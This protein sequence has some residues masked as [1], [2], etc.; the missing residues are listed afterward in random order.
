MARNASTSSSK[1]PFWG[2]FITG[3]VVGLAL[4]VGVALL[5]SRNNPF[6]GSAP[7]SA[8][9][10]PEPVKKASPT[11]SPT[12]DFY[13]SLPANTDAGSGNA[14]PPAA[15]PQFWLQAG[16]FQHPEEADNM[17]AK[18]ALLGLEATIES[19]NIPDKGTLYRVRVGPLASA[20][21]QEATRKRLTENAIP[22]EPVKK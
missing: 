10:A 9:A 12:Y 22:A 4:A 15:A 16:A 5:V 2:G 6:M 1:S 8:P 19:A 17:K 14:T 13:K 18:L 21:E 3:L 11:E 20:E 7:P